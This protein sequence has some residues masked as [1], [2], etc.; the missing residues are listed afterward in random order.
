VGIDV[1][2]AA[3]NPLIFVTTGAAVLSV[4]WAMRQSGMFRSWLPWLGLAGGSLM[5]VGGVGTSATLTPDGGAP[6]F[7]VVITLGAFSFWIW[8]VT[9][10]VT[11]YRSRPRTDPASSEP[12]AVVAAP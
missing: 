7:G 12:V 4:S 9:A 3:L 5:M 10:A 11:L 2:A 1:A 8:M 6:V